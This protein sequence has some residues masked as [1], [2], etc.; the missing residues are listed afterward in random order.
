MNAS[1]YI[2]WSDIVSWTVFS[3]WCWF[4]ENGWRLYRQILERIGL[5]HFF[6]S[7]QGLIKRFD[8]KHIYRP[9]GKVSAEICEKLKNNFC[10]SSGF[11]LEK[12]ITYSFF[13]PDHTVFVWN[14]VWQKTNFYQYPAGDTVFLLSASVIP[15]PCREKA[16][17]KQP[18]TMYNKP[19]PLPIWPT[20]QF[21]YSTSIQGIY[22]VFPE[23]GEFYPASCWQLLLL[24][25]KINPGKR[26]RMNN[27]NKKR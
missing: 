16:R 18:V 1:F 6:K 26:T 3:D 13:Y 9:L 2:R 19:N 10:F 23:Y 12:P 24:C 20:S 21:W 22:L 25:G 14:K 4:C 7:G 11:G 8:D 15:G 27:D 17:A 5:D